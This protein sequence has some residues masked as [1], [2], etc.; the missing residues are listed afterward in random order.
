MSAVDVRPAARA[1]IGELSRVLARAFFEDPVTRWE[2]PDDKVRRT[3]LHHLWAALI[4]HHHL[5]GGGVEV[6]T[7]NGTISAAAVWDPP[8]RW[9]YRRRESLRMMPRLVWAFGWD[10]S[11]SEALT[12]AMKNVHPHEPHWYLAIVGSDPRIR[13]KGFG[14][15]LMR[16]RLD[17]CDAEGLPAYLESTNPDNVPYYRRF[18]FEVTGE[19]PLPL[20]GPNLVP[21]WREPRQ[22]S[23]R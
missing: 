13:P 23:V 4:R 21:M 8:G 12:E 10:Q 3:K 7:H 20:G 11:R 18:G 15:A 9:D 14:H 19:I 1:D 6:A 5:A 17:R 2:V 16:S 22:R